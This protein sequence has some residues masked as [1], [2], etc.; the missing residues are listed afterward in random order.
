M[1]I[2]NY[3]LRNRVLRA[4]VGVL[5]LMI[6]LKAIEAYW[7]NGTETQFV[8]LMKLTAM[9][10]VIY[11]AS[12]IAWLGF[13]KPKLQK[14]TVEM[15]MEGGEISFGPMEETEDPDVEKAKGRI[16]AEIMS[17]QRFRCLDCEK[18]FLL[19]QIQRCPSC[20]GPMVLEEEEP[21]WS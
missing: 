13:N 18:V 20:E 7:P 6:N 3:L 16:M 5:A 4:L 8:G 17:R 14:S 19:P 9:T 11:F 2:P 1:K 12:R 21:E 15:L 10:I